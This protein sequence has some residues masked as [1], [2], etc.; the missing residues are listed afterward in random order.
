M[1]VIVVAIKVQQG[2]KD[3]NKL[4]KMV[5]DASAF[6]HVLIKVKELVAGLKH[7]IGNNDGLVG[8]GRNIFIEQLL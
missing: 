6:L 7:N 1:L 5:H 4:K 2:T 3:K 8:K